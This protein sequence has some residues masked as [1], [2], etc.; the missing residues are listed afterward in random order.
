MF[1]FLSPLT[2]M[3]TGFLGGWTG[4]LAIAVVLIGFGSF[5]G[6]K[7]E[8]T[9][10]SSEVLSIQHQYD[11][12]KLSVVQ[13]AQRTTQA[14]VDEINQK[15]QQISDLTQQLFQKQTQLQKQSQ[16][17]AKVLNTN[18]ASSNAVMLSDSVKSYLDGLRT[19][20]Q[21]SSNH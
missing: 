14:T 11:D 6:W 4:Y 9:I 5:L 15:N 18:E 12:Y 20:Q 10:A 19:L 13:E 1:K 17:L 3:V 7:V 2:S 16:D 21:S 8:A